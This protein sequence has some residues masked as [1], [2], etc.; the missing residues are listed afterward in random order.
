MREVEF[1][2]KNKNLS[3]IESI[4]LNPNGF[5]T[6]DGPDGIRISKLL[7]IHNNLTDSKPKS[8]CT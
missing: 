2:P 1:E 5:G 4:E 6:Y 8:L 7:K 3:Y